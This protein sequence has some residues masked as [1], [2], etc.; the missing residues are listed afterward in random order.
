VEDQSNNIR[1]LDRAVVPTF[2]VEPRLKRSLIFGLLA[3]LVLA[4]ALVSGLEVLDRT[5]KNHDDIEAAT[6]LAFLGFIPAVKEQVGAG[7]RELHVVKHP[8]SQVAECCRV[9]RTNLLFCSPDK[10]L[11]K[12]LVTSSNAVDGKTMT[13]VNLGVVMAQGGQRTLLVDTDLRRPRLH[14][15]LQVPNDTGVSRLILADGDIDEAIKSTDVPGMYLLPCG[16]VPPNPAELLQTERFA[17]LVEKLA[18]KFD[19]VIFDSPPV[20]AVTDA[21]ILSRLVDGVLVIARARSTTRD[22]L[23]RMKRHLDAVNARIAG[24]ALNDVDVRHPD[25]GG[26]YGYQNRY[27]TN[28]EAPKP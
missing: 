22:A 20:L 5:V 4:L 13:V 10:P 16:P 6:G 27:Y 21:P 9:L 8:G 26:Y 7:V 1:P 17:A 11:K 3:G 24:V 28:P 23:Q 25:Y 15:V 12:I 14:K 18:Q 19:R 2:P